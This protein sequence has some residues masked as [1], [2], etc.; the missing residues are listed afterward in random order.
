MAKVIT[1]EMQAEA[2]AKAVAKAVKAETKRCVAA[3]KSV[4]LTEGQKPKAI[5]T[6]A[7][8]A[9]NTVAAE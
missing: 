2:V 7:V 5:L 1:P 6:A 4:E 3:V 8:A 9:I